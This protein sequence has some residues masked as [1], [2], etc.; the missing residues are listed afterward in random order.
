MVRDLDVDVLEIVLARAADRDVG[1]HGKPH[2]T[3]RAEIKVV[4]VSRVATLGLI[5][6]GIN[7]I[8]KL[9]EGTGLWNFDSVHSG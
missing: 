4:R 8:T 2:V 1:T 9:T 5:F 6:D 7:G 3:G